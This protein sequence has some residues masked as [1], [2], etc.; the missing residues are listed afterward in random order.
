MDIKK[1]D[2]ILVRG[3]GWISEEI[4]E[5]TKSPY[6]HVAGVVK[7]NELVE[8]NGLR[9]PGIIYAA[10]DY[11]TGRADVFTCDILTDEQCEQIAKL[12]IQEVGDSYDYPLLLWQFFRYRFGWRLP[13]KEGKAR[14]CSVLWARLYRKVGIDLCPDIEYPS[15]AD[16]AQSRLLRKVGSL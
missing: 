12:A 6:S 8:A 2:L 13:Y 16:L 7:P 14:E 4:E 9:L 15:P 1:A 5:I 10:L 3:R 11:Y